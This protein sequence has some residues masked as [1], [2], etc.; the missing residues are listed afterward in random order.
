MCMYA[1]EILESHKIAFS[2]I[3]TKR[4]F[5]L[6]TSVLV[7]VVVLSPLS[8]LRFLH[9]NENLENDLRQTGH[10]TGLLVDTNTLCHVPLCSMFLVLL[11]LSHRKPLE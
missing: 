10:D 11:N 5:A 4:H 9:I 8:N 2:H 7:V 3:T 6:V 1:C